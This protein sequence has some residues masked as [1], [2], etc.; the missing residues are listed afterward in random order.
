MAREPTIETRI[1]RTLDRHFAPGLPFGRFAGNVLVLSLAGLIPAVAV[2]VALSPGLGA[3]LAAGTGAG[4]R[5]LR[6]VLTNGLP[7]VFAVNFAGFL[8]YARLRADRA[9]P[10]R[11]LA[12]DLLARVGLFVGLHAVI[13]ATSALAFGSFGGDPV[14]ALRVVGPTLVQAAAFG[15]LSGAYL[16]ATILSALPLHMAVLA[17]LLGRPAGSG[18]GVLLGLL[19]FAVQAAVLTAVAALITLLQPAAG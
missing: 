15:N 1:L 11:M 16:Y 13:F 14:Q 6:Q 10:G 7:V 19:A 5:F 8:L 2:F 3:H 9:A 12:L 17:R 4:G 18:A